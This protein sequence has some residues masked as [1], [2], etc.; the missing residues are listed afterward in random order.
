MSIYQE[1]KVKLENYKCL[2]C[3][4]LDIQDDAESGD[5]GYNEW[6]CEA[7]NGTGF[8]KSRVYDLVEV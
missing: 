8:A 5:M 7:C 1:V 2:E 6:S 3:R 4:G